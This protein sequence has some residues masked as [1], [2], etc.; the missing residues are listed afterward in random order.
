MFKFQNIVSICLLF[1]RLSLLS[2]AV[3]TPLT[4]IVLFLMELTWIFAELSFLLMESKFFAV[5]LLKYFL[6]ALES[7]TVWLLDDDI[8]SLFNFSDK[9]WSWLDGLS[10]A[11]EGHDRVPKW[12]PLILWNASLRCSWFTILPIR[13]KMTKQQRDRLFLS[14]LFFL[15]CLV[16]ESD[17]EVLLPDIPTYLK[18]ADTKGMIVLLANRLISS[19][20]S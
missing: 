17:L 5:S 10:W 11:V 4:K 16:L 20:L 2:L 13:L 1:S 9:S 8:Q 3:V 7:Q 6:L 14:S 12:W 15:E 19:W 18:C